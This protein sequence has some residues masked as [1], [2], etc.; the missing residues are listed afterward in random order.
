MSHATPTVRK[1]QYGGPL[2]R[3]TVRDRFVLRSLRAISSN[4]PA[5]CLPPTRL[6]PP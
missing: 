4:D 1:G 3:D 5:A 6:P 2:D